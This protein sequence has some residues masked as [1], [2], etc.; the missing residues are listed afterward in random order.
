MPLVNARYRT[1]TSAHDTILAGDSYAGVAALYV[2]MSRPNRLGALLLESPSLHIGDGRLLRDARAVS[3]WPRRIYLG[4]GT[5]EGATTA[6]QSEMVANARRLHDL[7][8][9]SH[10]EVRVRLQ[11]TPGAEHNYEAWHRRL[12]AALRFVLG[13]EPI[14]AA[15]P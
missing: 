4:V 15:K 6:D 13:P 9:R 14:T 3:L 10:P 8:A 1:S 11:I 2:A 5:D 12:P 7:I